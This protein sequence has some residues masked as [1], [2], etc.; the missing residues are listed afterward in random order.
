M[1][2]LLLAGTTEARDLA[3]LLADE[4]DVEAVASFAGLTRRPEA[5][6]IPS[7]SGGFGGKEGFC[8]YLEE[9]RINAVI[10]ATHP[11][12]LRMASTAAH[13]CAQTGVAHLRLMRPAWR[14]TAD[15][16]WSAAADEQTAAALVPAGSHVFLATGPARIA[17]FAGLSHSHVVCRRIDPAPGP[18]PLPQGYFHIAKPPFT[19][20]AEVELFATLGINW[21]IA[22]NSGGVAGRTKLEAARRLGIRVI[23]IDRPEP[24]A[25]ET[26]ETPLAALEW[27]QRLK[28]AR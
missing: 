11:F 6:P 13:I 7:R 19:V 18:F 28:V 20:A 5:L 1:N 14:A 10:D 17:A 2:V 22:R 9:H 3:A 4:P 26:L 23:L 16:D 21:L 25:C 8:A 27:L 12:A 24:C 15:D